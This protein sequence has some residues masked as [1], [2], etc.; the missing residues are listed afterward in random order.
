MNLPTEITN[1]LEFLIL[2]ER[3]GIIQ[4]PLKSK[5][6]DIPFEIVFRGAQDLLGWFRDRSLLR[7][8]LNQL[9]SRV[10]PAVTKIILQMPVIGRMLI[11]Q[12]KNLSFESSVDV[13]I[14]HAMEDYVKERLSSFQIWKSTY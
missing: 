13:G 7:D 11:V 1:E 14:Q 5:F 8:Y 3:D 12:D 6:A 4:E 10:S 9:D 2:L